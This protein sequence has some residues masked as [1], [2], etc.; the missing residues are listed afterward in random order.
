MCGSVVVPSGVAGGTGAMARR[1]S[2]GI[3][4]RRAR[5]VRYVTI[6]VMLPN[7][8]TIT[9]TLGYDVVRVHER[10]II[11]NLDRASSMM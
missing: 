3:Y 9:D 6:V 4:A 10:A 8:E 1:G 5:A 2:A 11:A 7:L